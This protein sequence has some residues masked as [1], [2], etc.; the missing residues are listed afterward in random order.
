MLFT[1]ETTLTILYD[2]WDA[3]Q[4]R[5]SMAPSQLLPSATFTFTS[6]LWPI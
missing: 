3:V 5:V 4:K 2:P 6:L 1:E